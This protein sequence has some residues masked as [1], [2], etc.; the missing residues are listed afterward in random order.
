MAAKSIKSYYYAMKWKCTADLGCVIDIERIAKQGLNTC[1][2][3][4][5]NYVEIK[6][7]KSKDSC[8]KFFR[9]GKMEWFF[10]GSITFEDLRKIGRI[11]ARIGQ[12][13]GHPGVKIRI[14]K[15]KKSLQLKKPIN[16]FDLSMDRSL[17]ILYEPELA[18]F[19]LINLDTNT[20]LKIFPD[21]KIDYYKNLLRRGEERKAAKHA[22]TSRLFDDG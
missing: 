2:P 1:M 19:A 6:L 11:Y 16:L 22:C 15:Y 17:S 5:A 10:N 4:G 20:Q 12:K 9:N 21:G 14:I 13:L 7:K 3:V 18:T 8:A